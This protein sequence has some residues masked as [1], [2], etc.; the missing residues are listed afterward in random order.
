MWVVEAALQVV[1]V[2]PYLP[3][4]HFLV[5]NRQGFLQDTMVTYENV[6]RKKSSKSIGIK[7]INVIGAVK[8]IRIASKIWLKLT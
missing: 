3:P 6:N 7:V 1:H 8:K 5:G 2:H 4:A